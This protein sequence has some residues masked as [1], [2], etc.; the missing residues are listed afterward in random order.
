M[1]DSPPKEVSVA[2]K[3]FASAPSSP[4]DQHAP[5]HYEPLLVV[6]IAVAAGMVLDRYLVVLPA[7]WLSLAAIS[8]FGWLLLC[9]RRNERASSIALL[10]AA[11]AVGGAWHHACWFVVPRDEIGLVLD[12]SIRP[13]AVE[14]VAIHSPRWVPA[15]PFSAMRIVPKG[16]ESE[17]LVRIT[18]VRIA[19]RWQP[20]SG[21]AHLE[22]EGHLEGVHAGD[23]L[24]CM[25][26]AS[27][28]MKPLNPGEFDYNAWQRSRGIHCHLR[29]V[30]PECITI[31][32]RGS[33]WLPSRWLS[34]VRERG[35]SLVRANIS[36]DRAGLASAVLLGTREQLD[37]DRSED[38]LL[39]GT[40]H[41]LSISGIHVSLLASGFWIL[42]RM[43][44]VP[45]RPA[46]IAAMVLTIL[47]AVLID[48]QPPVLRAAVLVATLCLALLSGR[49]ALSWNSLALAGLLV[50]AI[51]PS[52]LFL[53]GPQLSFLA[54]AVMILIA[55][56]MLRPDRRTPLE[57]LIDQSRPWLIQKLRRW[58][59]VLWQLWLVGA[60]IW[61]VSLPIVWKQYGIISPVGLLL[62][63]VI[64]LPTAM[65]M[66]TGFALLFLAPI[67]PLG[68]SI[69]GYGCD[70]S[71]A[72]MEQAIAWG[73]LLPGSYFKVPPPPSWW[74]ISCYIAAMILLMMPRHRRPKLWKLAGVCAVWFVV[75]LAF[76]LHLPAQL[77][78]REQPL[79]CTFVAVGH[80]LAVL[81]EY[82]D[83]TTML[84]DTGKVGAP[85]G[86][87]RA[88]TA[89]LQSRGI[90]SLDRIVISHAD[91]DHF[92]GI[93]NLLDDYPVGQLCT[94]PAMDLRDEP[95]VLELRAAIERSKVPVAHLVAGDAWTSGV[96]TTRVLHPVA[97]E[98]APRDNENSL[99]LA[100][101]LA[102]R[103]I[104]L[105]GDLEG[106]ALESLL[107]NAEL[108][109]D[110]VL[111]PHHGSPRSN[112]QGFASWCRPEVVVISGSCHPEDLPAIREV[113]A[114]YEAEGSSVYHT[115]I[116]G[117]VTIEMDTSGALRVM[118]FRD[119]TLPG[120]ASRLQ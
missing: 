57:K 120:A 81:V 78:T 63:L 84:Y 118:T 106:D 22:V 54:V 115:Q 91:A 109:S 102:G 28:P 6:L 99:V 25:A 32:E 69:A 24:R 21:T 55:P 34:M 30:L 3:D 20:A 9:F 85:I 70:L 110:V 68:A 94:S 47:Y 29:A 108:D 33:W 71:L 39:T 10:L 27:R 18:A 89:V 53:A 48:V 100:I 119:R 113:T 46:L 66:Y 7:L 80:G 35:S 67:F 58:L 86:A 31:V 45:R 50:L 79:R 59:Y 1:L 82:P 16:E 97:G 75:G 64:M 105:T 92:A 2:T 116:D 103:R 76:A 5:L 44:I 38:F 60:A 93:P 74:T 56:W 98:I 49:R 17:L 96:C 90:L 12:E 37:P 111:A 104:L 112:P 51:N 87:S 41:V 42:L 40:I 13:L 8:L 117:S 26:L 43:G 114:A 62:N 52:S 4:P 107:A 101:E 73:K 88:V 72:S 36:S 19:D 15:P 61:L 23:K 14:C 77:A 65:A 83:G 95:A 11:S